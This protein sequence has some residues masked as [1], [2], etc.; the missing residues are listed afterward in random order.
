MTMPIIMATI[1]IKEDKVEEAK[2]FL[3]QLAADTLKNEAG[4]TAYAA[5]QQKDDPTTFVFYEKYDSDEAFA[6]HG[7]NLQKV[8]KEFAGLLAGAPSL[9]FLEEL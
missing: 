3:K 5:H 7:Q 1:K 8:G 4:T 6:I 2:P 9:V